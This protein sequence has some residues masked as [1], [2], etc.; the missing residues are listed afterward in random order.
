MIFFFFFLIEPRNDHSAQTIFIGKQERRW[1]ESD[2]SD[3]IAEECE[4]LVGSSYTVNQHYISMG[5]DESRK[6]SEE[7]KQFLLKTFFITKCP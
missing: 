7:T 2:N 6:E 3:I 1:H 5:Y 4:I